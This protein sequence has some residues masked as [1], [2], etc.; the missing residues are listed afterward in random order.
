MIG[1]AQETVAH[2]GRALREYIEA[3]YHVGH[4]GLIEQRRQLLDSPGVIAQHPYLESTPRYRTER[5]FADIA[6][7]PFPVLQLLS[8]LTSKGPDG[9]QL[10]FDPPYSHQSRAIERSLLN[11][12]SLV[13]MTGTGSGKTES[14][15]LPALGKLVMEAASKPDVFREQAAIR[16][17]ILY[18]MNALVNDQLGRLRLLLGDPRTRRAFKELAGRPIRFARYTGRTLYPG[19][20]TRE[21]DSSRLSSIEKY[22]LALQQGAADDQALVNELKRRGKWPAKPDLRAW[23]GEPRQRWTDKEGNFV[24]AVTLADDAELITRHEVQASPPDLVV[25]NYSMLEYMLMRPLER[26][27]FNHTQRWLANNP[28][29]RFLLIVDEAHLYRGAAGAEVGYLIRRLCSRLGIGA[30]RLQVICTSAS[31]SDPHAAERF[32]AELTGK[33]RNEFE[34]ITGELLFR[35]PAGPGDAATARMLAGIDLE[36]F[37]GAETDELR[38]GAVRPLLEH[39]GVS[40]TA[41]LS[42]LLWEGLRVL[43]PLNLLVNR[44][45]SEACSAESLEKEAFPD[46]PT[47]VAARALTA[48][49]ALASVARQKPDQPG[50]LPARVHAF[51]RGL[52][53]LWVCMDPDCSALEPAVRNG[54]C[55]KLYAQP[56]D[57]C[58]CGARVLELYTCRHCGAAYARA[59]TSDVDRPTFLW[60]EPGGGFRDVSGD[61][62]ELEPIDLLLEQPADLLTVEPEDYDLVTGRLRPIHEGTRTR[63]VYLKKDRQA[64]PPKRGETQRPSVSRGEFIPCGACQQAASFGRS[65][66]QDHQTKGDQPFQALVAK[67][68]EVQAPSQPASEFAPNRGRKVLIFSDSRQVAAGLRRTFNDT[69]TKICCDR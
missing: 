21:K 48:L 42:L 32:A 58:E 3:T 39:L 6:G 25:T 63:Q 7:L 28:D 69:P 11:G 12:R 41:N 67:Q 10:L 54:P 53:G 68:L 38:I 2:L 51:F 64:Q 16:C 34:A 66:V 62:D 43:P 20:R 40:G 1:T 5:S 13:V 30:E 19:V 57:V 31:F 15:L 29:E 45:M 46:V 55:G 26:S 27:I 61:V 35:Q 8:A 24:R 49:M 65:S 23:Y 14:F 17:L 4:P 59:Y 37:Y 50:L 9:P 36:V 18:P 60:N 33:S 22:Y 44:T 47:Q 52:P 56:K